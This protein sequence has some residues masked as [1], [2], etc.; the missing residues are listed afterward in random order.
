MLEYGESRVANARKSYDVYPRLE[1]LTP[2]IYTSP[3]VISQKKEFRGQT[4]F[5]RHPPSESIM[6]LLLAVR[7]LL[8]SP[9][10]TLSAVTASP[11]GLRTVPAVTGSPAFGLPS[12]CCCLPA[13]CCLACLSLPLQPVGTS[14]AHGRPCAPMRAPD[15][16]CCLPAGCHT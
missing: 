9:L 14:P 1:G 8:T 13:P 10:R 4:G 12:A 2:R 6:S 3:P 11:A 5:F 15:A 16:C 7:P